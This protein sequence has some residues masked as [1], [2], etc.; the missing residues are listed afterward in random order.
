[1]TVI[2]KLNF[3]LRTSVRC[4]NSST[5]LYNR[6]MLRKGADSISGPFVVVMRERKR[7]VEE[8]TGQ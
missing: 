1:M 6:R 4:R 8:R 2:R 7:D 5:E 3:C